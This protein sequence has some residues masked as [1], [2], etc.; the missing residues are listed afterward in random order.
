[1]CL[2]D[3]DVYVCSPRYD[4]PMYNIPIPRSV[5]H[6]MQRP[7][8]DRDLSAWLSSKLQGCVSEGMPGCPRRIRLRATQ[9]VLIASIR[10]GSCAVPA[11]LQVETDMLIYL[12]AATQLLRRRNALLPVR[13]MSD[14]R[15][16]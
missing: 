9:R 13:T 5:R 16:A 1:M 12:N 15:R 2:L 11:A 14:C 7:L 6:T 3:V 4:G 8:R 10:C